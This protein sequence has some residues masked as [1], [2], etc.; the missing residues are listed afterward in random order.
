MVKYYL[1]LQEI[2]EQYFRLRNYLQHRSANELD[3]ILHP[4]IDGLVMD[5]KQIR[6]P[7]TSN[8]KPLKCS[9]E[10]ILHEQ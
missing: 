2:P 1:R 9:E 7:Y 8:P 4:P 3:W 5:S 10:I 6:I